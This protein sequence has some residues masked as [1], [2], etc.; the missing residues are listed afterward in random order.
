VIRVG[1]NL[2]EHG[3]ISCIYNARDGKVRIVQ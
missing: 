3:V 1:K 2:A